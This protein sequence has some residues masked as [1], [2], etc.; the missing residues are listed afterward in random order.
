[1]TSA[2]KVFIGLLALMGGVGA[3]QGNGLIT[4]SNDTAPNLQNKVGGAIG[5]GTA[6]RPV[7]SGEEASAS[8]YVVGLAT[9]VVIGVAGMAYGAAQYF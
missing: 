1:M 6:L 5:V 4:N 9:K 2:G 7:L 8:T 3:Q